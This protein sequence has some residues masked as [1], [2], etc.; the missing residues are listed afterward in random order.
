MHKPSKIRC[1]F[2]PCAK[3]FEEAH[4]KLPSAQLLHRSTKQYTIEASGEDPD[5]WKR[6]TMDEHGFG[7]G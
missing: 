7:A 4:F 1:L 6:T 5:I 2:G 3:L